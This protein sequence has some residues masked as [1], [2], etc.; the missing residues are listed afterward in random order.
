MEAKGNPSRPVARIEGMNKFA[1]LVLASLLL[2]ACSLVGIRDGY[3]QPT[4]RVVE[5]IGEEVEV[6]RY[7][8]RFAAEVTVETDDAD[9]G[10]GEAFRLLFD[11]ITGDNAPNTE[12]AMTSPVAVAE[13]G[14]KIEMT[15][16]VFT[17]ATLRA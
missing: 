6:R 16:P 2:G 9:R 14:A 13:E 8:A 10:T 3:E 17:H 5:T 7:A 1:T 15:A 11:Y 4:Y 12:I